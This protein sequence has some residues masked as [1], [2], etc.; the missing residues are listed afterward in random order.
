MTQELGSTIQV[1]A[2]IWPLDLLAFLPH[3]ARRTLICPFPY[4]LSLAQSHPNKWQTWVILDITEC[5]RFGVLGQ[6]KSLPY[7][8]KHLVFMNVDYI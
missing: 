7:I 5:I 4:P 6:S 8:L 3:K 2:T 1:C